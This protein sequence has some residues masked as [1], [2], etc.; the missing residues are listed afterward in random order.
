MKPTRVPAW[1]LAASASLVVAACSDAPVEPDVDAAPI[2]PPT[3]APPA[4]ASVSDGGVPDAAPAD[5]SPPDASLVTVTIELE[6]TGHGRVV[7]DRA[8]IDCRAICVVSAP[9]GATLSLTA[10]P[11]ADSDF[12]SWRGST[13]QSPAPAIELQVSGESHVFARFERAVD[14]HVSVDG[15]GE[16]GGA[17]DCP[18]DCTTRRVVPDAASLYASAPLGARFDGWSGACVGTNRYCRLELDVS[19]P[20]HLDVAATFSAAHRFSRGGGGPVSD[21]AIDVAVSAQGDVAVV[22]HVGPHPWVAVYAANGSVRFSRVFTMTDGYT[23]AA[24]AVFDAAGNLFVAGRF[25]GTLAMGGD[26]M[27]SA[28]G[29]DI[30]LV[31][32]APDGSH[33]FSRHYGDAAS[34]VPTDLAV[35]SDGSLLLGGSFRGTLSFGGTPL[36]SAGESDGF[37]ARLTPDGTGISAHRLGD[38]TGSERVTRVVPLADQGEIIL[39]HTDEDVWLARIDASGN[40]LWNQPIQ[41]ELPYWEVKDNLGLGVTPAGDI[42]V[43]AHVDFRDKR[44]YVARYT[45]EGALADKQIIERLR[46]HDLIVDHAGDIVLVGEAWKGVD[47]GGG[48]VPMGRST[49]ILIAKLDAFFNHRWSLGFDTRSSVD[50]SVLAVAAAPDGTI[51]MCGENLL[52]LDFGGGPIG[53]DDTSGRDPWV[54]VFNP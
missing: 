24:E 49:G 37:V 30:F 38:A 22:G 46:I 29:Y 45:D 52:V 18:D 23:F 3:D 21:A 16:V 47:L 8:D 1:V 43:A 51:A 17:V 28:G 19:D 34:E 44:A 10:I 13:P 48:R 54:A 12:M 35:A 20:A 50:Q 7:A 4:D 40:E 33:R 41:Q 11:D 39:G 5:A 32:F 25:V 9:V 15:P 6:G 26:P 31:S 2:A 27:T 42:I 53:D 14:I 36:V